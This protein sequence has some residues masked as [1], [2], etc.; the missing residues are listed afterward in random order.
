MVMFEVRP[1]F[2]ALMTSTARHVPPAGGG[3]VGGVLVGGGGG[4]LVGGG[5]GGAGRAVGEG[6]GLPV[7]PVRQVAGLQARDPEHAGGTAG[8]QQELLQVLLQGG[9][10]LRP[11]RAVGAVLDVGPV[12][13]VA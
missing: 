12:A 3:E 9:T 6:R 5:G 13:D 7:L 10:P 11:D 4:V 1:V 2:H 8:L